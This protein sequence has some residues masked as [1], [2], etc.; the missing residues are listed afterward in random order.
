VQAPDQPGAVYT[1]SLVAG[2]RTGGSGYVDQHQ[3]YPQ[4]MP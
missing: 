3:P 2:V 4:I 1:D